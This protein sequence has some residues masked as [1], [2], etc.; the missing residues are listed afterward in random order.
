MTIEAYQTKPLNN[1][2]C[3]NLENGMDSKLATWLSST[4]TATSP[5]LFS[6]CKII[7]LKPIVLFYESLKC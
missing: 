6:V 3:Q 7:I 2:L 4:V 5:N 1:L